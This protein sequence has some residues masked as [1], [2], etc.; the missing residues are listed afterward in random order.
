MTG[1]LL[2]DGMADLC[3]ECGG[4][5]ETR[6]PIVP[7]IRP[8]RHGFVLPLTYG[9][10]AARLAPPRAAAFTLVELMVV[11]A[12]IAIL[13]LM[14]L[15]SYVDTMVREQVNEALPLAEIAKKP[16]DVIWGMTQTLPADNAAVGLPL[17]E[18][19]VSNLVSALEVRDGAIYMTFGNRAHGQ[20]KGL[21]LTIRP[22][23][24][25]DAPVVPIAWVCGFAAAPD[26]MSLRGENKTTVPARYLPM[27]CREKP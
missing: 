16:V 2:V 8:A 24:V 10:S 17:P 12:V 27:K 9:M 14:M 7:K 26:K 22:A 4:C 18:K 23:L 25:E 5:G 11:L 1:T 20:L 21:V 15:P 19:V 6:P 13:A 3:V